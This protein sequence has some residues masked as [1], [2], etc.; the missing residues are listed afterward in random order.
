[1]TLGTDSET[2]IYIAMTHLMLKRLR[3]VKMGAG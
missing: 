3:P 2:F 1:M